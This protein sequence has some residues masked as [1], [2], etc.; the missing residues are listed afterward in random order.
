MITA[1]DLLEGPRGRRFSLELL[2]AAGGR[3]AAAEHL[4]SVLFWADV[5]LTREQGRAVALWGLTLDDSGTVTSS[6]PD[7]EPMP[8]LA[9]VA[10][11]LDAV[12]PAALTPDHVVDALE[13]TA[14]SALWWQERDATDDLLARPELV[15]PLRRL[16]ARAAASPVVQR[17]GGQDPVQWAVSFEGDD[18]GR[19]APP[20]PEQLAE[21]ADGIRA[22]QARGTDG[23]VSGDWWTTPPWPAPQTSSAPF[24]DHGP[25]ALWAVEDS[26]GWQRAEVTEAHDG[27]ATRTIVIDRLEDWAELCRR[28]PL[29]VSSTT[30]RWDWGVATGRE[31]AWVMPDWTAAAAEVDVVELTVAGWFRCSGLAVPVDED[32]ASVVAGWTPGSR[33]WLT[34]P[35][36]GCGAHSTWSRSQNR[37]PWTRTSD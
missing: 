23:P 21:W 19:P 16:A 20:M 10:A 22:D 3:S 12:E 6:T 31:G 8:T 14:E 11:A 33:Y 34:E 13:Q 4:G 29:D 17:L 1:A 24:A 7:A 15:A 9:A 36:P 2:R 5:R 35:G 32:R 37:G 30:R 27:R 25:L 26:F 28:F 18:A